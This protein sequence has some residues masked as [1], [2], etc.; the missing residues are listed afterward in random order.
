MFSRLCIS[1]H[2]HTARAT[3]QLIEFRMQKIFFII[4][5]N[6]WKLDIHAF[7]RTGVL[8]EAE[9]TFIRFALATCYL[10]RKKSR[11]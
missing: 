2:T 7:D 1:V 5:N 8:I 9:Q 4:I 3:W 11:R 10:F 6:E